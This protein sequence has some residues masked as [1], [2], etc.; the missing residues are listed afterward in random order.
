[1]P[2]I[3]NVHLIL[4]IKEVLR[5]EGIKEY[6]KLKLELSA[7]IHELLGRVSSEH[8]LEP[9]IA[10]EIY[11]ISEICNDRL[12]LKDNLVIRGRLLSS[13]RLGAKELGLAVCSI[14]PRLEKEATDYFN[15][16]EPLRGLLLDGIGSAAVD[17]LTQK[18]CRLIALEAQ[19]RGYKTSSP[20]SPG[21]PGLPITQQK[22]LFRLVPAEKIGV[23]LT[24]AGVMI[25]LKSVSMIIGIGQGMKTWSQAEF[26]A[27]CSLSKTC[28]HRVHHFK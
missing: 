16:D 13:F 12:R 23:S 5:R 18:A 22:Q 21:M 1:M 28:S 2:V 7:L 19:S 3:R 10:Y 15:E 9:A 24:S 17:C 26:C 11:P 4:S 14:G 20:L 6:P 8:L 25:P 27:R